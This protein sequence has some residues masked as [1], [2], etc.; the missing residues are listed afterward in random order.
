MREEEL[1]WLSRTFKKEEREK[2]KSWVIRHNYEDKL[3]KKREREREVQTGAKREL[4]KKKIEHC[5][6]PFS[7]GPQSAASHRKREEEGMQS[8]SEHSGRLMD[9]FFSQ[10][11][12]LA[13]DDAG[14]VARQPLS[15]VAATITSRN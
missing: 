1:S 7:S 5:F 12:E 3:I 14:S 8:Q 2:R 6:I 11:M 9:F 13:A 10:K 15:C 4:E